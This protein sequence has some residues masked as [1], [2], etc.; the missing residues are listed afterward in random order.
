MKNTITVCVGNY[1]YYAEGELRDRWVTLPMTYEELTGWMKNNGLMD[2]EHEEVY[3]SDYDGVPFH[4]PHLFGEF[5]SIYAINDLA[6]IMSDTP[7]WQLEQL[8]DAMLCGVEEPDT[9]N[10]LINLVLQSDEIPYCELPEYGCSMSA[11]E[12]LGYHFAEETG[13]YSQLED[14]NIVDYFD[15]EAYGE[16]CSYDLIM[17]ED[18]Y[19]YDEMPAMDVYTPEEIQQ[20]SHE[21]DE[22]H[23]TKA[24]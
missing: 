4:Q 19:M 11:E 23:T 9:I 3:V 16:A 10:E 14:M 24:A 1:G 8:D 5:T 12:K 17:S 6:K 2:E 7:E 15:F 21:W 20:M 13:L 18:G 22:R